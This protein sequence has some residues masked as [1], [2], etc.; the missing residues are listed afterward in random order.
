MTKKKVIEN[1]TLKQDLKHGSWGK[2]IFAAVTR[3][4]SIV[5]V[6]LVMIWFMNNMIQSISEFADMSE[7]IDTASEVVQRFMIYGIPLILL[8]F[9]ASFYAKGNKAKVLFTAIVSV[10]FI[11]W[12][13][14]IF[15][16]GELILSIDAS[17]M[18]SGGDIDLGMVNITLEFIGIL[19]ILVVLRLLKVIKSYAVYKNNR[20]KYMEKLNE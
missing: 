1:T 19:L 14:M 9:F 10:Y 18:L 8:A 5:V 4:I 15:P 20:E 11:F 2:G 6:P 13:L 17:S 7:I 16:N 12:I 3:F